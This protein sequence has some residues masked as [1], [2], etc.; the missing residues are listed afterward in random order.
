MAQAVVEITR[1]LPLGFGWKM[2]ARFQLWHAG[3]ESRCEYRSVRMFPPFSIDQY[4]STMPHRTLTP[5]PRSRRMPAWAHCLAL[6]SA[7]FACATLPS[8]SLA[9]EA[10]IAAP[11]PSDAE[12]ARRIDAF[13]SPFFKP[14]APGATVIVTRD[15]EPIFRKAY[16]MADLETGR[17]MRPDDVLR[18]A[19][20]TKQFTAVA[21][22]LLAEEG[23]LDLGD[24]F[25]I[26]LPGYPKPAQTITIDQLLTH[27]SGIPGYTELPGF[28]DGL[29]RDLTPAQ[30]IDRFASLPL[31]FAPGTQMRY[32]NSAYF[33]LGAIIE[34]VSGMSYADFMAKRIFEPLGLRDTAYEGHERSGRT[35]VQGYQSAD[36]NGAPAIRIA[37]PISMTQPYS[38][39][40]LV[41]TIDDLARWDAAIAAG[42]LL[43]PESWRTLFA[44]SPV[45]T[46]NQSKVA[47]GWF[48]AELQGFSTAAHSGGI[49]GFNTD[50]LRIPSEKLYSAILMNF[51]AA[52][53]P[54]NALN[55][56]ISAIAV[57]RPLGFNDGG[58]AFYLRGS[59]NDWNTSAPMQALA[60]GEYRAQIALAKGKHEFKIGSAD[61]GAVD[62]GGT[63]DARA[64]VGE[65]LSLA[66]TGGNIEF[67]AAE[68]GM[69]RFT[70]TADNPLAPSLRIEK[71]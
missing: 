53:P 62:F 39:G 38:A 70:L 58:E 35:R 26:H 17:A 22:M 32:N 59:M 3:T 69:Y 14:D 56:H 7:L 15:G 19:S 23:K 27:T 36:A 4:H 55:R 43:K 61:W 63:P 12:T 24:D 9:Q 57:G 20:M 34:R 40:A 42:E 41:S 66:M 49:P 29:E 10:S 71:Q 8:R 5:L 2:R 25:T 6:S 51:D 44:P 48:L 45:P 67:V 33:L 50:G 60:T 1:E 64:V 68:A 30:M 28:A 31:Q 65:S 37:A 18:L 52:R 47:R 46:G 11:A 21:I 54:A 13:L 16:G